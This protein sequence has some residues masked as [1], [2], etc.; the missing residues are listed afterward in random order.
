SNA[1][2]NNLND[3]ALGTNSVTAAA[4]PT[5]ST[6]IGGVN[7]TFAGSTPTSVVSVGAPGAERQITNVAA[8]RISATS[9][10]AVNGSQLNATNLAVNSLS[11]S[12]TSNIS[13]LSTGISSLSTGLSSTNSN[14]ASLSTGLSSTNSNVASLSTGVMTINNQLSQLSTT[15]N[16]QTRSVNNSGIV[17][18]MNGTGSDKPTVTAGSNSAAIGA[19]ST[20]GGRSNVVS[21]GSDTQQRQ[22]INV[23]P[24]TQGTDAV[25]V[26][27]LNTSVAQGVQQANNYT[28]QRVNEMNR[29]INDVAK[30]A[31]AGVA[32]A[33]AMPNLTP[34]QPGRTVVG[35]GVGSYKSGKAGAV[36]ITHRSENGRWLINGGVAGTSTGDVGV[37]AQV[38][39][40]W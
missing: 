33:M 34:S 27:Q 19:N 22:I 28:D 6:T 16:N 12:T 2:A 5:P 11:T 32:A 38:G 20:D 24:G 21:V 10:D 31:Y 40:E 37:R 15:I 30:N 3:V 14:V 29:A 25:N 18:D 23:A 17:A 7:Y 39:Y 26:N 8:G 13:S 9:T 36:S 35:V 4:N 1:V